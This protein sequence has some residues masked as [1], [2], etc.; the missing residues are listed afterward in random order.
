MNSENELLFGLMVPPRLASKFC[1]RSGAFTSTNGL[2]P[3]KTLSRT[4]VEKPPRIGPTPACV[5]MSMP[6]L[7]AEWFSAGNVSRTMRI[8]RITSRDGSVPPL[9]PSTRTTA[10]PPAI[11]TS[12]RISSFGSS[13]SASISSA[14][15]C[16][17][18]D[19]PLGSAAADCASRP[20]STVSSNPVSAS[21]MSCLLSPARRRTLVHFTRIEAAE[22]RGDG[23]AAGLES[24]ER[25]DAGVVGGGGGGRTDARIFRNDLDGGAGQD[26]AGHI[27]DGHEQA[28]IA[29]RLRGGVGRHSEEK[30]GGQRGACHG[31]HYLGVTHRDQP[32]VYP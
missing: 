17:D 24:A 20:T 23:V 5:M 19:P 6:S 10:L 18:S 29:R 11:S 12:W 7:S 8:D 13:G 4:R 16:V 14:V 28:R 32:T 2:S 27:D 31:R 15:S 30:E 1:V 26:G 22:L 25:R 21:S 3:L 9:K